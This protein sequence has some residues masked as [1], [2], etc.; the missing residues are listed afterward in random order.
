MLNEY[1]TWILI[2]FSLLPQ[3]GGRKTITLLMSTNIR[4]LNMDFTLV[5]MAYIYPLGYDLWKCKQDTLIAFSLH[6]Q[7]RFSLQWWERN[8]IN[9]H[10]H[11]DNYVR[12]LWKKCAHNVSWEFVLEHLCTRRH[13][14]NTFF[15]SL[16]NTYSGKE[17]LPSV[18]LQVLWENHI[19]Q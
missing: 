9:Y 14:I 6:S 1:N 18:F 3:F 11:P 13:L 15:I 8:R 12:M 4:V 19:T 10:K 17:K 2:L 5:L 16:E 7:Q